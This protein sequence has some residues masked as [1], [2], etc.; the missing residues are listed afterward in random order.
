ME[1]ERVNGAKVANKCG[2]DF[3]YYALHYCFPEKFNQQAL[4][5]LEIEKRGLFGLQL[6]SWLMGTMF[7]FAWMSKYLRSNHLELSVNG[8]K[9]TS[10][11]DFVSSILFSRISYM[12]AMAEIEKIID[13]EGVAGV[14]ISLKYWGLL[15]HIMFVYGCD[16][17][18]T[19][20]MF[21]IRNRLSV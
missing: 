11:A 20:S 9:I 1:R 21:L 15:D 8:R 12:G 16:E 10:F 4:I 5:P 14:D 6:P 13:K 7:Q 19:L 17:D 18:R 3:L 2:R